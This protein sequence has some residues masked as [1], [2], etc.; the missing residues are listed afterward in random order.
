[1]MPTTD[2]SNP[3]TS[4]VTTGAGQSPISQQNAQSMDFDFDLDF[5]D[6]TQNPVSDSTSV[7]QDIQAT[8]PVSV[9]TSQEASAPD[10]HSDLDFSLDLP[11]SYTGDGS[12]NVSSVENVESSQVVDQVTPVEVPQLDAHSEVSEPDFGSLLNEEQFPDPVSS[13]PVQ[14]PVESALENDLEPVEGA[15]T[16]QSE[17]QPVIT[18][19][20]ALE[21]QEAS[22]ELTSE[23]VA[24]PIAEVDEE[25]S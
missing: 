5:S 25:A 12:E 8:G 20:E 13:G 2:A 4:S 11:D 3:V 18:D 22:N 14:A 16:F 19:E 7:D 9:Q 23:V 21:S 24:E 1:M 10:V 15:A 17:D 6:T